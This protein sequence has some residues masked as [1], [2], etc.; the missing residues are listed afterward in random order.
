MAK[1]HTFEVLR[2]KPLSKEFFHLKRPLKGMDN[3][4]MEN[5]AGEPK[6]VQIAYKILNCLLDAMLSALCS[7]CN[8]KGNCK[9]HQ[10]VLLANCCQKT[11]SSIE[12][13]L[14]RAEAMRCNFIF[15]FA[16]GVNDRPIFIFSTIRKTF[17][18]RN[19]KKSMLFCSAV[20]FASLK[21]SYH[22]SISSA[23][24]LNS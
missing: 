3:T 22:L 4:T 24:Y 13:N 7:F 20:Q 16:C 1:Q 19:A 5:A 15:F 23:G 18:M 2:Q 6:K 8:F 12:L 14:H 21:S 11:T 10:Q 9:H 17:E